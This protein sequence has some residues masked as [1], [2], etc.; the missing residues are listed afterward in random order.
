MDTSTHIK[1][2]FLEL[3]KYI[4]RFFQIRDDY[5]N[6][7]SLYIALLID[8]CLKQID[9]NNSIIIDGVFAKNKIFLYYLSVLRQ[10][11]RIFINQESNGTA[12][13][14]F[15]LCNKRSNYKLNLEKLPRNSN[16]IINIYKEEWIKLINENSSLTA[17]N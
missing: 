9:S 14:A 2:L 7:A 16:Q 5:I 15:L 13:G 11:Q 4:G 10:N 12:I 1:N 17:K 8:Y 3:G 6:L